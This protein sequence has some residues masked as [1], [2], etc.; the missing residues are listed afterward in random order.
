M[1]LVNP[2]GTLAST[3]EQ[4]RRARQGKTTSVPIHRVGQTTQ[5]GAINAALIMCPRDCH[6]LH[7]ARCPVCTHLEAAKRACR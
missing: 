6:K 2:N 3:P 1:A 4:I 7:L 5:A